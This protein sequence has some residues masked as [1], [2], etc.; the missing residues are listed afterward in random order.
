MNHHLLIGRS[1]GRWFAVQNLKLMI[2]YITL[3]YEIQPIDKRP[4]SLVFGDA[5]VPSMSACIK[6]RRRRRA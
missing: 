2:A 4:E 6:V 3:H 1:P 5:N